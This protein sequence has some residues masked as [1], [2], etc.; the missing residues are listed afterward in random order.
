MSDRRKFTPQFKA[1]AVALV[2]SSEDQKVIARACELLGDIADS[3][4]EMT[5]PLLAE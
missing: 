1:D 4:G 3:P 2:L 5:A